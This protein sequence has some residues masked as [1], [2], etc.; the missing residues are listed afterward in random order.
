[1]NKLE[2]NASSVKLDNKFQLGIA[3]F[4]VISETILWVRWP[5][6]QCHS[7]EGWQL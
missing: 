4:N 3:G 6:Q 2:Y 7:T 5:K 1:M